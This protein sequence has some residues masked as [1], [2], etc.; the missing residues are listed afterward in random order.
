M[1]AIGLHSL[2]STKFALTSI[3]AHVTLSVES[4]FG[5]GKSRLKVKYC[6]QFW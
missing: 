1:A 5:S 4:V 6:V 2:A 3:L